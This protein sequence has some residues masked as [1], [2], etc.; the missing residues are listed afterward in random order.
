MDPIT[1]AAL[2]GAGGSLI[3]GILGNKANKKAAKAQQ[4]A[5]Q[6]S[7]QLQQQQRDYANNTLGAGANYEPILKRMMDLNGLN[8]MAALGDA[9]AAFESAPEY[10]FA[11]D[12]A[13]SGANRSQAAAGGAMSGRS[14]A[15]LAKLGGNIASTTFNDHY[16]KLA[17]LYASQLGT[18]K[19]LVNVNN[20]S[21]G[22]MSDLLMQRGV[23]KANKAIGSANNWTNTLQG[24]ANSGSYYAGAKMDPTRSSYGFKAA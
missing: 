20:S 9:R 22:A 10:L 8:G 18:A 2:A 3:S 14:L 6:Q 17:N 19:D 23:V 11:R 16:G 4:Q 15:E 7:M 13:F 24:I 1:I 21:T 12:S 5:I